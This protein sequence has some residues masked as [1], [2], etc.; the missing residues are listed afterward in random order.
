MAAETEKETETLKN[1]VTINYHPIVLQDLVD[2]VA[3][4]A[5]GAT[6]TFIGTTRDNFQGKR[7][8]K[9]EYEAYLTMAKKCL[10]RI[11]LEARKQWDVIHIAVTHRLG[12]CDIGQASVMIAVSSVH[13]AE[14]IRAMEY[15]INTL[16]ASVPIWKSEVYES[17]QR[18]WK[19]NAEWKGGLE[20]KR[21]G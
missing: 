5:A 6:S 7:V 4:P 8:I 20:K 21:E 10:S 12:V 3:S 13:R 14:S 15:L 2:S 19:E 16:K 17:E 9:L 18:V 1:L 11:C